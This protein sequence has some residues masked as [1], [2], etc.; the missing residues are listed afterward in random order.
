MATAALAVALAA[1]ASHLFT[2]GASLAEDLYRLLDR[3][4]T[5][6]RLIAARAAIGAS[7][8]AA[9]V[10]LLI[11]DLDPLKTALLA[12]AFAAATFFPALL[13]AIWWRR[14]TKWGAMAAMTTGFAV[15]LAE[16]VLGGAFGIGKASFSAPL[17]SLIGAA[18][19]LVAGVA[20]SL[21]SRQPSKVEDNYREEMRDPG[22]E[23]IYDRAQ[24]RA[25]AAAAASAAA[26]ASGQ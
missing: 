10:F 6:P 3:R 20:V 11:A 19:A 12:F 16:A 15:M 7:A 2:L 26:D 4:Q 5:L 24:M 9:A 18:L 21:Y 22:G 13:L 8:L 17:A 1:S 14:C 23:T 25:A